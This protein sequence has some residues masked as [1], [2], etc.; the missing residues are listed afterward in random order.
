MELIS[1]QR[2]SIRFP[3]MERGR[4]GAPETL[5]F[6]FLFAVLVQGFFNRPGKEKK[7]T[8][9]TQS[10]RRISLEG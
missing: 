5:A 1:A 2:A 4:P 3:E 7:N 10:F 8:H 6:R 9:N